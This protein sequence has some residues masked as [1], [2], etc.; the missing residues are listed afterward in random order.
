M[1]NKYYVKT[2]RKKVV[3]QT[4]TE[5]LSYSKVVDA[6]LMDSDDS[7]ADISDPELREQFGLM[8]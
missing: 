2:K 7:W 1:N 3:C 8:E 5:W 4:G 6:D